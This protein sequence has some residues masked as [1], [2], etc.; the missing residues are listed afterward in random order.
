MYVYNKE[1]HKQQPKPHVDGK[2]I[3]N[4]Q[5]VTVEQDAALLY[6]KISVCCN[7]C[8]HS[9]DNTFAIMGVVIFLFHELAY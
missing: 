8:F 1:K 5:I 2:G 7:G 4:S 3:Q 6:N 9:G